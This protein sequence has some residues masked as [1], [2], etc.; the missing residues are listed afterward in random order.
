[1][2]C[3]RVEF[4]KKNIQIADIGKLEKL[5]ASETYPRRPN[6]K[7]VLITQKDQECVF[8]VADGSAKLSG[9]YEFQEPTLRRESTVKRK[10]PNGESPS[11]REEFQPEETKDDEGINKDFFALTQKLGK[12]HVSSTY[13]RNSCSVFIGVS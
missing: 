4:C 7:E 12:I 6:A 2:L 13:C 9:D 10:N 3:S 1:M 5:N 11:D 8:L